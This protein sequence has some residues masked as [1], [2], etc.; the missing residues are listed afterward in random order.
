MSSFYLRDISHEV[1]GKYQNCTMYN[2]LWYADSDFSGG[3]GC[4]KPVSGA[5]PSPHQDTPE[6]RDLVAKMHEDAAGKLYNSS[7][8]KANR[9]KKTSVWSKIRGWLS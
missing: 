7:M 3:F 2:G 4:G 5:L 6:K 9:G 1:Y 8:M